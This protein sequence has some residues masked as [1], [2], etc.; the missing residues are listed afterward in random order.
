[1]ATNNTVTDLTTQTLMNP[2]LTIESSYTTAIDNN[3]S[4]LVQNVM[5]KFQLQKS[6]YMFLKNILRVLETEHMQMI[7]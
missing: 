7:S 3:N 6:D 5:R 4:E 1:M 2:V